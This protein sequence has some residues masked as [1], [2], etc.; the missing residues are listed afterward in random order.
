MLAY[1]YDANVVFHTRKNPTMYN[2]RYFYDSI[3]V[4]AIQ[5]F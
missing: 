2:K 5:N 4:R 3:K 1:L